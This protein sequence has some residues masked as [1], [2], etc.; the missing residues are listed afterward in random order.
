M[1][2]NT[3]ELLV[4]DGRFTFDSDYYGDNLPFW[5]FVDG[6]SHLVVPYSL[7]TNDCRYIMG[8]GF[9]SPSDFVDYCKRALDQLLDDGDECGRMLSIGIHPRVT[10][11]PARIHG[12]AE[13]IKYAKEQEG[14]VFMRRTDIAKKFI[15]Q[16][17][18]PESSESRLNR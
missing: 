12:L 15:E 2:T 16:V 4:E 18:R 9:G 6:K 17:P 11:H 7:V 10:G 1:S 8:T 3:R 13:F 5:T 14:V